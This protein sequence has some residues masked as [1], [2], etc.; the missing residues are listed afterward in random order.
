MGVFVG[1]M[2]AAFVV[3]ALSAWRK[4]VK[5]AIDPAVSAAFLETNRGVQGVTQTASGLQYSVLKAGSGAT[6]TPG[7]RVRITYI[8]RLTDGTTFDRSA[9]PV[10]FGVSD[11]VPGFSEALQLMPVGSQYRVWIP[12]SL[13]YGVRG[14]GPV[15]PNA[16]LVF[17]IEL[18]AIN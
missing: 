10:D 16:V 9:A 11:V 14:A 8:G 5:P 18:L 4:G 12:P 13:G 3:V 6:P 2:I 15:P 17:D 1:L 7:D